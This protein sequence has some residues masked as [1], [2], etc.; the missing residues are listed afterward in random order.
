MRQ[1]LFFNH[2]IYHNY[3]IVQ[4]PAF[5]KVGFVQ[6][7]QFMQEAEGSTRGN[8]RSKLADVG[9]RSMLT[10]QHWRVVVH[11]YGYSVVAGR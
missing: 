9:N 2:S 4:I 7:L 8:L 1:F 6:H 3:G 10:A 5:D 11:H